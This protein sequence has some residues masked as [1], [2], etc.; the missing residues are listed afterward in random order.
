MK[1]VLSVVL[2]QEVGEHNLVLVRYELDRWKAFL[3]S[4]AKRVTG[5]LKTVAASLPMTPK[6][7]LKLIRQFVGGKLVYR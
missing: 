5:R 4:S 2:V 7:K 1:L 3:V 6:P